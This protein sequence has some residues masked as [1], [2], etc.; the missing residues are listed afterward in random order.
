VLLSS[1]EGGFSADIKLPRS[2]RD[3]RADFDRTSTS[4]LQ[5]ACRSCDL[6]LGQAIRS[7]RIMDESGQPGGAELT[8]REGTVQGVEVHFS[9]EG[10]ATKRRGRTD[11]WQNQPWGLQGRSRRSGEIFNAA[12]G[13]H[14]RLYAPR[15]VRRCQGDSAAFCRRRGVD[16]AGMVEQSTA[17]LRGFGLSQSQGVFGQISLQ[18][19]QT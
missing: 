13:K 3:L 19:H 6:V 17:L 9:K 5:A 1:P 16:C 2:S 18:G 11:P 7:A 12:L 4:T 15:P 8:F 14:P 10:S